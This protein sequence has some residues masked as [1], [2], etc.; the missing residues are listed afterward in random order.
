MR[1]VTD[2][3]ANGELPRRDCLIVVRS[4]AEGTYRYLRERLSGVRGIE[5][6]LDRGATAST[7]IAAPRPVAAD[8]RRGGTRPFN[9]LGVLLVRR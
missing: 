2:G 9:A 8:E 4:D 3:M 5:V 6:T 1:L 7:P